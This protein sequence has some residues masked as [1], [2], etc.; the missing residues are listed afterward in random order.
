M[1]VFTVA[2]KNEMLDA[3]TIA[4]VALFNGDPEAAGTEVST[5]GAVYA[6]QSTTMTAASG[7]SIVITADVVFGVPSGATVNYVAYYN[8]G[9]TI[10]L[11]KDPVT[12]ET[13]GGDG[14]Y[15][16]D[17]STFTI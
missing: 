17:T 12:E 11:A 6:R 4:L 7:G 13:Y 5:A 3:S 8:A 1:G 16:V 9:G 2:G 14:Y 15:T 10:L